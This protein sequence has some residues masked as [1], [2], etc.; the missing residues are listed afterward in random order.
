MSGTDECGSS[1]V[2]GGSAAPGLPSPRDALPGGRAADPRALPVAWPLFC[3]IDDALG[4]Y[5]T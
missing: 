2:G 1:A 4:T 3:T 5:P